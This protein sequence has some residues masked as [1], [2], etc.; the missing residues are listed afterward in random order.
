MARRLADQI[1]RFPHLDLSPLPTDGL[2]ERDAAFAYALYD[3]AARRWVTINFLIQLAL[4][5]P[6]ENMEPKLRAV[7]MIGVTQLFFMDKVPTHAAVDESVELAKQWIRPGAGNLANA[8]LRKLAGLRL[9]DAAG[10]PQRRAKWMNLQDELAMSSGEALILTHPV[11]PRETA[12]RAAMATSVTPWFVTRLRKLKGGLESAQSIALHT[13][14][15]PPIVLNASHA[16]DDGWRVAGLEFLP[17]AEHPGKFI[18]K[19]PHSLLSRLLHERRDVW[20]QDI[21]SAEAVESVKDLTPRVVADVCAGQ[22]TKSRQ[23]RAMFPDATLI[24]SDT[25]PGR[26]RQLRQVFEGV[27]NV[28]VAEARQLI[29]WA[30]KVDLLLLDVPCSNSGVL[31]RRSEAAMRLSQ[32]QVERMMGIQR[33]IIADSLPLLTPAGMVLYSTCSIEPEENE[34]MLGWAAKWHRFRVERQRAVLP[35]GLPGEALEGYRDGAFSGLL[36]WG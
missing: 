19:G 9:L 25:D 10:Y 35:T 16:R 26:T 6:L 21:S 8:V 27:E 12:E 34:L 20:A 5:K 11:L 7:L 18:V 2:S 31:A 32:E 1:K 29:Q 13:L 23:L 17:I 14:V 24:L 30:G 22:G 15:S 4:E 3:A 28:V 33:Q 36:R